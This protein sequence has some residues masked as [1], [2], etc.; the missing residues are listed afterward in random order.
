MKLIL[1]LHVGRQISHAYSSARPFV[2]VIHRS[3]CA[4]LLIYIEAIKG[5]NF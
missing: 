1:A 5:R 2:T 4:I 3:E